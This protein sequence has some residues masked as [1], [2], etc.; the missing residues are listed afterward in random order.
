VVVQDTGQGIAPDVVP[1]I[2]EPFFTTKALG[3]GTG[4]GLSM[5]YGVV[6][7]SHG[8]ISVDSALGVGNRF[9]ILLPCAV[10]P[11]V[12]ARAADA[13][14]VVA[15]RETVL[16][17]DD[18]SSPAFALTQHTLTA[19][20][21]TVVV[22]GGAEVAMRALGERGDQI[23]LMLIDRSR[24]ATRSEALAE[25][26][27][28]LWPEL[29]VLHIGGEESAGGLSAG[30]TADALAR[31]VRARLDAASGQPSRRRSP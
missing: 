14:G 3:R 10:V 23:D 30:F 24:A 21:Y 16:L 11:D 26:A 6:A 4:L 18:E 15:G 13:G 31:A 17:V 7:Q 9:S 29:R 22:A 2:F 20:G 19:L 5:A 12:I 25:R 8:H 27:R 1:R 28:I